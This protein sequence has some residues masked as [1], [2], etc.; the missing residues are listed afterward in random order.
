MKCKMCGEREAV[1]QI[2]SPNFE[3][4]SFWDVCEDC[5]KFIKDAQKK[6]FEE[7]VKEHKKKFALGVKNE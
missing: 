2:W 7:I 5:D 3:D 4:D 6:M 1:K